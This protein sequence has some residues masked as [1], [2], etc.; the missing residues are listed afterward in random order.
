MNLRKPLLAV[1]IA[2]AFSGLAHAGELMSASF[3]SDKVFVPAFKALPTDA[4]KPFFAVTFGE[5]KV[6]AGKLVLANGRVTLGAVGDASG[7]IAESTAATRPD[8][9][10]D[11]SKP[12]KITVKIS[13]ASTVVAGKDTFFIYV[14]NSTSKMVQSPLGEASVIV[15]APVSELKVGENVFTAKL[16][17]A[18][19]FLQIRAES[20][21]A[22]KIESIK[23][24]SI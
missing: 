16:G 12:Y 24:E 15:R 21:A 14:N 3:T 22:L 6:E 7:A 18:K 1:V 9:V 13:E 5:P 17:D 4:S 11:L 23:V 20:G 2:L 19:S 8:G 10:L